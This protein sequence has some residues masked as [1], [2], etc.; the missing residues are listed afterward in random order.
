M[1]SAGKTAL[2]IE[3]AK[4]NKFVYHYELGRKL[5]DEVDYHSLTSFDEYET[6]LMR[7]ELQRD[8]EI[9][10]NSSIPI[11]ETWHP[12]DMA[13]ATQRAPKVLRVWKDT[14]YNTLTKFDPICVLIQ[15]TDKTF[16]KRAIQGEIMEDFE[17]MLTFYK[18]IIQ[19]TVQLYHEFNI[20]YIEI[21]NDGK[22][23]ETF[24]EVSKQLKE[25]NR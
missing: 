8:L 14:F 21:S 6:E 17:A 22:F 5:H 19:T 2:A 25:Y 12:G 24:V 16:R 11:V 23:E 15:I 7:R 20:P 1:H 18:E 3:Y 10:N 4:R 13:Y 9:L